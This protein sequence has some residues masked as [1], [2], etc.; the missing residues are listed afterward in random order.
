MAKEKLE[1]VA[2]PNFAVNGPI[3][4]F[5]DYLQSIEMGTSREDVINRIL[6]TVY[7]NPKIL[8][9]G[10]FY[11][12]LKYNFKSYAKSTYIPPSNRRGRKS[13]LQEESDETENEAFEYNEDWDEI[14]LS[15]PEDEYFE[16]D[17]T[18]TKENTD[19]TDFSD[20]EA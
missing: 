2:L 19:D 5:I 9:D 10:L 18:D 6:A 4:A 8:E 20:D 1:K 13:M 16:D 7:E 14:E 3:C 11:K 17:D 15:D 12:N